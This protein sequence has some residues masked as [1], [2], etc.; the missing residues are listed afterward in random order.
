MIC[1]SLVF[2][3]GDLVFFFRSMDMGEGWKA[4]F[5][6]LTDMVQDMDAKLQA[7]VY[8]KEATRGRQGSDKHKWWMFGADTGYTNVRS[9]SRSR[10]C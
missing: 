2:T 5:K 3:D 7:S 10:S 8:D 9:P 4:E 1:R 6:A